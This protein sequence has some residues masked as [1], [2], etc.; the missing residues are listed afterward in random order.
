[1]IEIALALKGFSLHG[2]LI[3]TPLR[4]FEHLLVYF[5]HSVNNTQ[6]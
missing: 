4:I 3:H 5:S 6:D 2:Y 1:M